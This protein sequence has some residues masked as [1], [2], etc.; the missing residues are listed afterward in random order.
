MSHAIATMAYTGEN[1]LAHP[2]PQA[3][4]QTVLGHLGQT[5]RHGLENLRNP[6]P[7]HDRQRRPPR[8]HQILR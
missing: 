3:T 7:L 2:W 1:P 8:L 5:S 4:G 6:G